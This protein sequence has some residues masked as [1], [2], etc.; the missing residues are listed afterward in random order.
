V[1]SC[2][3]PTPAPEAHRFGAGFSAPAM[4]PPRSPYHHPWMTGRSVQ[5]NAEERQLL[6]AILNYNH[7]SFTFPIQPLCFSRTN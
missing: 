2:I 5:H 3:P 4:T 1:N 6:F 7:S